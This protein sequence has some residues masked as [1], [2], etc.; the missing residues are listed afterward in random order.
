MS[1]NGEE[2]FDLTVD[3]TSLANSTTFF[4]DKFNVVARPDV[5][6]ITFW[7]S[8]DSEDRFSCAMARSD[9]LKTLP[10]LKHYVEKANVQPASL[11]LDGM[12]PIPPREMAPVVRFITCTRI[13]NMAETGLL[14]FPL[15]QL[16]NAQKN[17]KIGATL[18]AAVLSTV[19]TQINF[20]VNLIQTGE[21][22]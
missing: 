12:D 6:F 7:R 1:G 13:D 10:S 8:G 16:Y 14:F 9:V 11:K 19:Q 3:G 5:V 21:A 22:K 17:T 15:H 20:L 18:V 4:F 2:T